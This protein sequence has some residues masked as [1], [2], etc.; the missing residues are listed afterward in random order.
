MVAISP[1]LSQAAPPATGERSRHSDD[2][3]THA[4]TSVLLD[5]PLP[6][7]DRRESRAT[8]RYPT[9]PSSSLSPLSERAEQSFLC[10]VS[11]A[12]QAP[13]HSAPPSPRTPP[14]TRAPARPCHRKGQAIT[15][16]KQHVSSLDQPWPASTLSVPPPPLVGLLS[17][18]PGSVSRSR[19]PARPPAPSLPS[20]RLPPLGHRTHTCPGPSAPCCF[21]KNSQRQP[22]A[23]PLPRRKS[24][25]TITAPLPRPGS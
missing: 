21:G 18:A 25:S 2:A 17:P 12:P 6:R 16:N 20:R 14:P 1:G 7:R 3:R 15:G 5:A 13:L 4:R 10:L 11:V 23:A 9:I 22:Q 8:A 19:S 24:T